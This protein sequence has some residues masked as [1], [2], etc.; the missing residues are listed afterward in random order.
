RRDRISESA[1]T[2]WS[3]RPPS[4]W[5]SRDAQTSPSLPRPSQARGWRWPGVA[6]EQRF[7]MCRSLGDPA[8]ALST[9]SEPLRNQC[10]RLSRSAMK[11]FIDSADVAE[12]KTL[13]ETGLV[14]GVTTNPTLIAKSGGKI[15]DALK[16]ICEA[17]PGP[18]SAEVTATDFEAM[19]AEGRKLRTIA[20]NI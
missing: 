12:L 14:D 11:I 19:L 13:A 10:R 2:T 17:I 1:K 20:P 9:E 4:P 8:L 16:E 5:A 7:A 6:A 3:L 18:I 15:F